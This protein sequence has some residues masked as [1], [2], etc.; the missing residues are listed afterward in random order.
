MVTCDLVAILDDDTWMPERIEKVTTYFQSNPELP[1]IAVKM[2]RV[3]E[4]IDGDKIKQI[5]KDPW[6]EGV[7][8]VSLYDQL[9]DNFLTN[10]CLTYR[11]AVYDELHGYDESL[12]V[13]EDWDFG[14]RLLLRYDIDFTSEV[15]ALYH[16]R[17]HDKGSNGN[18]VF[19]GADVHQR[20][21]VRL[22]NKYLRQDIQNKTLG[23]G[24]IMNSLH[25]ER[26]ITK[27]SDDFINKQTIRLEGHINYVAEGLKDFIRTETNKTAQRGLR[28]RVKKLI[29]R[30]TKTE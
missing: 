23:V 22:R 20:S 4:E 16:H 3:I 13:A 15:L 2:D 25:H 19:A 29:A 27:A 11:R 18:S 7:S 9:L 26:I 8:Q 28:A 14:V 5:R 17:P 21:L 24:Y 12:E 1:A 10:N 30:W 6:Y